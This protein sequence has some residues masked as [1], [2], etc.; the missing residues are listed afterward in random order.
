M[1][2]RRNENQAQRRLRLAREQEAEQRAK[3]QTRR[4]YVGLGAALVAIA[5]ITVAIV[6]SRSAGSSSGAPVASAPHTSAA[7]APQTPAAPPPQ[8]S[9]GSPTPAGAV[10]GGLAA[11]L[12]ANSRQADQVLDTTI[13]AKLAHLPGVPVVINQW[14]SW[15]PN[16]R[17]E[18]PFFQQAGRRYAPRI[19]FVGLDSQDSRSNARAFLGRFPVNYPSVFDQ[20]AGQA[21]SLGAGQGWPTT[22]FLNAK[23]QITNI[24]V[25]AYQTLQSL[26]QDIGHYT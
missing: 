16:C 7:S 1:A 19:A 23:H 11:V 13:Q 22:I 5:A 21:Q 2:E 24:H 18:F 26:E 15:C 10:P 6:T 4:I 12:V 8:T 14:A 3:R 20:S 9:A 25:G 17:A